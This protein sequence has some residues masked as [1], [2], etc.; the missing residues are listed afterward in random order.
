MTDSRIESLKEALKMEEDGSL[1]YKEAMSRVESKL[2]K[3]VFEFLMKAE[4]EHIKKINHLY[5]SLSETGKWPD[6]VLTRE[7]LER[8]DNIFGKAMSDIDE[9]I[10]GSTT[11]IEALR[12]SAKLEDDGIKYYQSRADTTEE[13]FEKKFYLLMAQE[14]REHFLSILDTIEYLEDPQGYFSQRERGTMSF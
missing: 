1:Y 14:E 6:L 5:K 11:D 4:L 10:K 8:P 7:S 13:P 12:T 2:A 3:D 9:K